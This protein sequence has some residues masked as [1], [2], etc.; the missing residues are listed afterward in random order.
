[1][2]AKCQK[3]L[4]E[5]EEPLLFEWSYRR[6]VSR[7]F[8]Y[9]GK[10]SPVV[11]AKGRG[12]VATVRGSRDYFVRIW[13]DEAGNV[14]SDCS[15]PAGARCKHAV[16]LVLFCSRRLKDG[17]D[18]EPDATGGAFWDEAA[19]AIDESKKAREPRPLPYRP[20]PRISRLTSSTQPLQCGTMP[21]PGE[22]A[23]RR[24]LFDENGTSSAHNGKSV[25]TRVRLLPVADRS[26]VS[27]VLRPEGAVVTK[28]DANTNDLTVE[29][30]PS[31]EGIPVVE[32]ANDAA[33]YCRGIGPDFQMPEHVRRIGSGAFS[34][35]IFR[36]VSFPEALVAIGDLAFSG[37]SLEQ[38]ALT[39]SIVSVGSLAFSG[40]QYLRRVSIGA[41]VTSIGRSCFAHCPR[42]ESIEVDPENPVYFVKDG[43]LASRRS[44]RVVACTCRS[45]RIEFPGEIHSIDAGVFG[46]AEF[47]GD[48]VL[49]KGMKKIAR[50]AF[51]SCEGL[52]SV[53]IPAGVTEIQDGAFSYCRSLKRV[54][55]PDSLLSIGD[56]AFSGCESLEEVLLPSGLRKIGAGAFRGCS[57]LS[58]VELPPSL[59]AIPNDAFKGCASL[60]VA[61]MHEGLEFIGRRA[62][63]KCGSLAYV[64]VPSTVRRI[65]AWAFSECSELT[66]VSLP[67]GLLS[68][69][70]YT[71]D[72]CA[73]LEFVCIPDGVRAV[74]R[75]AF[76]G[77]RSLRSASLPPTLVDIAQQAF[78]YCTAL[79]RVRVPAS[80]V[81]IGKWAFGS[82]GKLESIEVEE[83]NGKYASVDGVLYSRDMK[84][85]VRC[86]GARN[87]V[88]MIPRGVRRI[89]TS[90]FEWCTEVEGV[91]IP[92]TVTV[93]D[94][95]AF[96]KCHALSEIAVPEGVV[97]IKREAFAE[98]GQLKR[99]S[100]PRSLLRIGY[101]A[102]WG[103]GMLSECRLPEGLLRI[104]EM[105]FSGCSSLWEVVVPEG[106]E[107]LGAHAFRGCA[108]LRKASVPER[109]A[110]HVKELGLFD[111]CPRLAF[112]NAIKAAAAGADVSPVPMTRETAKGLTSE[113]LRT[114]A[115]PRVVARGEGYLDRV[116]NV[117]MK[118]SGEV[119]A[120]VQG[121]N[122]YETAI[123]V[124]A[125]GG[126]HSGC[127]CPAQ[128]PCK[129]A[130]ALALVCASRVSAGLLRI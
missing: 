7:A 64:D 26:F 56:S 13:C 11:D 22:V 30:P 3:A 72:S 66:R 76:V 74:C 78:E 58:A 33:D 51:S 63:R 77:C 91:V 27:Y 80:V 116:T 44:G 10:L 86:P 29:L 17:F 4:M 23:G 117:R 50:H 106:V 112:G 125:D 130:V 60:A 32:F 99:V 15:C 19:R 109:W 46:Q 127:T 67:R 53:V 2:D 93:I 62:F 37:S 55:L 42:L 101:R 73:S 6:T 39:G 43:M 82:S 88:A 57:D 119:I 61:M 12:V 118:S 65:S 1:M 52:K 25:S 105:A 87:G 70:P 95:L 54:V 104:G 121:T 122:P 124:D 113:F 35:C 111:E 40:C 14:E 128:P 34:R 120:T 45:G 96:A 108:L 28:V 24:D 18:V 110:P 94:Q 36:R 31:I 5:V 114:W 98:C 16:A 103:C 123:W 85:L 59:K 92:G 8:G 126:L 115:D 71:F 38:V 84:T 48:V 79:E 49:P 89:G 20:L 129:H 81:H 41:S 83:G 9:L 100:L 102:F 90:A 75:R 107:K 68:I 47:T 97:A 69:A 21:N